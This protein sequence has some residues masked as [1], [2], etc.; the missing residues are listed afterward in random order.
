MR[1]TTE[2]MTSVTS[3]M[4]TMK[5]K[6]VISMI[7]VVVV[8]ITTLKALL[9]HHMVI[10]QWEV[11]VMVM[12]LINHKVIIICKP[13]KVITMMGMLVGSK[14]VI[15]HPGSNASNSLV[16]DVAIDSKISNTLLV[17]AVQL[18]NNSRTPDRETV[19]VDSREVINNK[20][21]NKF[22]NHNN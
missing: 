4:K 3:R 20:F 22:H 9:H 12:V 15:S 17:K 8:L 13:S 16:I 21:N 1:I 6:K 2:K 19:E 14:P 5:M 10:K 7:M 11:V 18:V